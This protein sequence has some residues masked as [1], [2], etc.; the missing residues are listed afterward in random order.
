M[1]N[2]SPFLRLTV[3]WLCMARVVL[4]NLGKSF[5]GPDGRPVNA[6]RRFNLGIVSGELLTL[7]GPSGCGKTTLLRLIAGLDTPAEGR[8]LFDGVVMNDVPPE[9]R[10]VAMVFQNAALF[11][12]LTAGENLELGLRLR[13]V[14]VAERR[15][16]VREMAELLGILPLLARLPETLSGGEKQ[17]VA[18]GRALVRRPVLVL[19]DEPLSHLDPRGRDQLRVEIVRLQTLLGATMIHVTHDQTEAVSMGH[20]LAV[21]NHGELQQ[22]DTPSVIRAHPINEFVAGFLSGNNSAANRC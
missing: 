11:P 10:D 16:R 15:R 19:L 12:H 18:L 3:H 7:V 6:V 5:P 21:M 20:R 9:A 22:V 14:P 4:E 8:I 2:H 13:A 1:E 17:R